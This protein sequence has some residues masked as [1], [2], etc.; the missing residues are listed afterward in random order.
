V[1]AGDPMKKAEL[2]EGI[3]KVSLLTGKFRLR[4]GKTSS[5]YWDKY[6]FE[7][8]P[9]LLSAVVDEMQKILPALHF[10]I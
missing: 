7:S 1:Q 5:F 10:Y 9:R 2:A 8:D 4:S 3:R 6:P